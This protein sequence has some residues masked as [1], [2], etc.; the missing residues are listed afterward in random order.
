[1]DIGLKIKKYLINKG[2]TQ[3]WLSRKTGIKANRI[4][5]YLNGRVR[6]PLA[7]YIKI[8]KALDVTADYFI[9]EEEE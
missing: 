6:I 1:M 2:I 8:V 4:N 7:A 3:K 5:E 9:E